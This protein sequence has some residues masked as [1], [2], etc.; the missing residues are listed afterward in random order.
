MNTILLNRN[1]AIIKKISELSSGDLAILRRCNK[2]PLESERLLPVLGKLGF[3]KFPEKAL[4]ACLYASYHR[5]EEQ[6]YSIQKFN[7][8]EAFQKAYNPDAKNDKDIRFRG[9]LAATDQNQLSYRLRQAVRLIK[10]QSI[11]IDFSI[12]LRDLY[13]W[14]S[15]EKRVQREWAKGYYSSF[16]ND[17]ITQP[18]DDETS[19]DDIEEND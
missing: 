19:F 18:Q 8:G 1:Q 10:S 6:P 14:N 4:I 15:E 7:F 5:Q 2:A 9:L 17:Q 12:L 16:D 11:P 13:S 3:L